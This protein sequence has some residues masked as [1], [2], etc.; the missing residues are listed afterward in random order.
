M[1][2]FRESVKSNMA[3]VHQNVRKDSG[4][5]TEVLYVPRYSDTRHHCLLVFLLECKVQGCTLVA[6]AVLWLHVV[7]RSGFGTTVKGSARIG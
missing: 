3:I 7:V 1:Q 2:A 4:K 5:L 6:V